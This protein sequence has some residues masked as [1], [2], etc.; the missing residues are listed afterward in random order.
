MAGGKRGDEFNSQMHNVKDLLARAPDPNDP[1]TEDLEDERRRAR[2]RNEALAFE[3]RLL[4]NTMQRIERC[5][6][7]I[8]DEAREAHQVHIDML[9]CMREIR[10]NT[11]SS[12]QESPQ[13][14]SNAVS[15]LSEIKEMLHT[16]SLV[17]MTKMNGH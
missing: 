11:A 7:R 10:D 8:R 2:D 3:M 4:G 1:I 17:A 5:Q 14:Q 12:A 13:H 6:T 15:L 9:K 16:I